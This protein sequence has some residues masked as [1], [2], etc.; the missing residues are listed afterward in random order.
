MQSSSLPPHPSNPPSPI[1][2]IL[3]LQYPLHSKILPSK[4]L[5]TRHPM[6]KTMTSPTQPRN[7]IQHPLIMPPLLQHL[8]MHAPRNKMMIRQRDPVAL[9]DLAGLRAR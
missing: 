4:L 3:P 9:A 7:T 8:G 1:L 6:H 5:I 2:H